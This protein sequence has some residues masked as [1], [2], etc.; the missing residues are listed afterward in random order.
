[1]SY[2]KWRSRFHSKCVFMDIKEAQNLVEKMTKIS[3]VAS[4]VS[5]L[6]I[7][8]SAEKV[9]VPFEILEASLSK[10]AV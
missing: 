7:R 2:V 8:S 9:G 4:I 1:M 3:N 5:S 6:V 10:E